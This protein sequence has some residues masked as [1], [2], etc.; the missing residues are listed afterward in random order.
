ME[1]RKEPKE[2]LVYLLECADGSL[3]CGVTKD[4]EARVRKH[5]LGKAS[6]YTRSR[7]PVSCVAQSP[8]LCKRDAFRLEYQ[9]KQLPAGRKKDRVTRGVLQNIKSNTD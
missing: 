5:N 9:T 7:L 6:R 1:K 3:Y 2:W 8:M 4:L